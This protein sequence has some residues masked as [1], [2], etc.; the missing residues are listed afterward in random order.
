MPTTRQPL[1][2]VNDPVDKWGLIRELELLHA[3]INELYVASDQADLSVALVAADVDTAAEIA[4]QLNAT[5]T[6]INAIL[7][8]IRQIV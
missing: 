1:K 2:Q 4:T 8:K 7:V 5:N 6:V 3:R